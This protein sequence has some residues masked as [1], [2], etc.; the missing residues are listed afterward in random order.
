M[1]ELLPGAQPKL[2]AMRADHAWH[3]FDMFAAPDASV[4]LVTGLRTHDKSTHSAIAYSGQTGEQ[5]WSIDLSNSPGDGGAILDS[6]GKYVWYTPDGKKRLMRSIAWPKEPDRPTDW[7]QFPLLG[8]RYAL[9]D[10][11]EG[12]GLKLSV[13]GSDTYFLRLSPEGRPSTILQTMTADGRLLAWGGEDGSV[14][15]ADLPA[16]REKLISAGFPGW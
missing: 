5:V 15:V 6:S 7:G 8:L 10:S 3:V 13:P 12:P 9:L 1:Y 14:H 11:G 16:V 4:F 2:L